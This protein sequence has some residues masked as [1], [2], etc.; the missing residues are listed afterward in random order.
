MSHAKTL[1]ALGIAVALVP[2]LGFPTSWKNVIFAVLGVAIV[3]FAFRVLS[4]L[5]QDVEEHIP[6]SYEQSALPLDAVATQE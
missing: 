3:F 1:I 5:Q 2:F 4:Q 6:T